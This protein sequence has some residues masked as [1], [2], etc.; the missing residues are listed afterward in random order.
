MPNWLK[1][2]LIA[3]ACIAVLVVTGVFAFNYLNSTP[4]TIATVT[5]PSAPTTAGVPGLVD[6][7]MN[8]AGQPTLVYV[9]KGDRELKASKIR[10]SV[11][12]GQYALTY[13]DT[14]GPWVAKRS[15]QTG[16]L[17]V[18]WLRP[19]GAPVQQSPQRITYAPEGGTINW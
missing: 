17:I 12:D 15:G 3:T 7:Q 4:T 2:L 1:N 9:S 16:G 6:L 11:V 8:D 13:Q 14:D 18:T 5:T 10:V 19:T